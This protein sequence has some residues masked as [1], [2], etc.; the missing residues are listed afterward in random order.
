MNEGEGM[1]IV[2]TDDEDMLVFGPSQFQIGLWQDLWL[3]SAEENE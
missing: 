1:S 3:S 2:L